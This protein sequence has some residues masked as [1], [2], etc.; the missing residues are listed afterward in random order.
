MVNDERQ[1]VGL[2]RLVYNE[3]LE[4]AAVSHS[5]WMARV[6]KMEHVDGG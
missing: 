3:K 6:G 4:Q 5:Q 1:K 2:K